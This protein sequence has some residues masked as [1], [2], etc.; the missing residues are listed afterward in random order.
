MNNPLGIFRTTV[1]LTAPAGVS[2]GFFVSFGTKL[3]LVT[4]RHAI[5]GSQTISFDIMKHNGERV[6]FATQNREWQFCP[7]DVD[8]AIFIIRTSFYAKNNIRSDELDLASLALETVLTDDQLRGR[9]NDIEQ[10]TLLGYPDGQYDH[11]NYLPIARRGT[12]ALPL[13][14]DWQGRPEFLIDIAGFRGNSGGPVL[15]YDP[16][17][18]SIKGGALALVPRLHLL[19][20]FWGVFETESDDKDPMNLGACIKARI[21]RGFVIDALHEAEIGH[22]Q[23]S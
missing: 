9:C 3:V 7:G 6:T 21:L 16:G 14:V 2:T 1:M 8:L 20:V 12:T 5:D 10:V 15:L 13:W 11:V 19:G 4:N 18:H 22:D 23:C 17:S